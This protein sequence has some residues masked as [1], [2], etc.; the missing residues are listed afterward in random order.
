MM[1]EVY[2]ATAYMIE[3]YDG[4]Q[5][6][7]RTLRFVGGETK[8]ISLSTPDFFPS[9]AEELRTLEVMEIEINNDI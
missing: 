8:Y 9:I 3:K 5:E 4:H 7:G 2:R 1:I 6:N